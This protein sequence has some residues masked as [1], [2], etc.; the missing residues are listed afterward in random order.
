MRT[1]AAALVTLLAAA[2]ALAAPAPKAEPAPPNTV[3]S[4]TVVPAGAPKLVSAF[5]AEGSV[6]A[7]GVTVL[8]VTFDQKMLPDGFDFAA[9]PGG[10]MPDCLKTPRLLS[11]GKTFVLLCTTAP[12]TAYRIALNAGA[13]GGFENAGQIRAAAATLAFSTND[14][15]GPVNIESAMKAAS[16]APDDTPIENS[17]IT[18]G[19][20]AP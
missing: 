7:P 19:R 20:G 2:P 1:L 4:V 8:K 5:P 13:K 18:T 15:Q 9:A 10:A 11:D 16:L 17:V 14:A 6:V 3:A 12:K